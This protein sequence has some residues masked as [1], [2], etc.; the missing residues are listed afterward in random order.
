MDLR[1]VPLPGALVIITCP[2]EGCDAPA[3]IFDWWAFAS[4]NGPVVLV[5]TRCLERHH[6]TP[7]VEHLLAAEPSAEWRWDAAA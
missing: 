7:L 6:L 3:E 4:T 2:E 5:R 1:Y